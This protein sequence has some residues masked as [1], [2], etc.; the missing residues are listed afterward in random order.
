MLP[1]GAGFGTGRKEIIMKVQLAVAATLAAMFLASPAFADAVVVIG[2]GP[3]RMC[4]LSAKTGID[5]QRGI[6]HCNMALENT[7]LILHDRA[8]TLVNRGVIE[9]K[10]GRNE[11]A[12]N[13]YN[14]CLRLVPD[15]PDAFINRGVAWMTENK[16]DLAL[17][18]IEKGIALGPS[19]PA[20][21]YFDRAIAFENLGRAVPEGN[22]RQAYLQKAYA[23]YQA[24]LKEAPGFT[25][26]SNAL[27]RFRV[28]PSRV[29]AS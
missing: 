16:Y 13:D 9:H 21:A 11:A 15:Q 26:A 19:E 2:D 17:A 8:A 28:V 18:D 10:L 29:R 23:D 6:D 22:Q 1:H 14:D 5:S 4:Y 27:A 24:A 3:E 25:A 20:L 12:M 7:A